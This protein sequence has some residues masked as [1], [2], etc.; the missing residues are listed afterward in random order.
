MHEKIKKLISKVPADFEPVAYEIINNKEID[1]YTELVSLDGFLF[2]YIKEN[3]ANRL[4]KCCTKENYRNLL[5]FLKIYSP[6]YADFICSNLAKYSNEELIK[7]MLYLFE[8][9]SDS[10]KAYCAKFFSIIQ[11]SRAVAILLKNLETDYDELKINCA[12]TLGVFNEQISYNNAIAKLSSNDDFAVFDAVKFLVAYG[13]KE[14]I[15]NIIKIIKISSM[16]ENISGELLYLT[17]LFEI[18][19]QKQEDALYVFNQVING[20]GDIFSLSQVI[21]FKLYDFIQMLIDTDKTSK[22][23]AVLLNAFDKFTTLT[24]N[25][26]YMFDEVKDVKDEVQYINNMLNM[27]LLPDLYSLID[28]ELDVNSL[29]VYTALD[30][31]EN[32]VK[33]RELLTQNNPTVTLKA[34]ESLKTM[35]EITE[36]DRQTA[37]SNV[38][39]DTIRNIIMVL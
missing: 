37:L 8:F 17:D 14:A 20:L 36:E 31:S 7:K 23:A 24:E 26:E 28:E 4:S 2:D 13:N 16:S 22:I 33:I 6:Y 9:G 39:D 1:L 34:L 25:D 32:I 18:Y 21:D 3:V 38:A 29:F 27:I 35:G 19:N 15:S 11:D 10:E 5:E 12:Q 30:F